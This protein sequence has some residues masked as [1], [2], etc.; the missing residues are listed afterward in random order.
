M[1]IFRG[2]LVRLAALSRDDLPMYTRWFRDY[3][4]QRLLG[5]LPV[6]MTDE[7]EADWYE[8]TSAASSGSSHT[9]SIRTLADD[10]LI[11]NCSLFSIDHKNRN[12][13][14]GIVIGEQDYWG[15]GYGSDAMRVL[16]GFGFGELN[17][18]RVELRVYDFNP[19]GVRAYEK[20]GFVHEGRKRDAIWR[21]GAYHDVLLMS[22]LEEE[23][24][25]GVS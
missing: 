25:G 23:W 9:F 10:V 14:L 22:I 21:E 4:V 8:R 13:E 12:A 7:A 11:G 3:E 1:D 19:R 5:P 24:R 2:E 17:L 15:R 6:P 20:V 16:L 18:H